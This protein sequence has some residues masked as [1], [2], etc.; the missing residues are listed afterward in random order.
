MSATLPDIQSRSLFIGMMNTLESLSD[1]D[2]GFSV[3]LDEAWSSVKR[4]VGTLGEDR[5]ATSF[6]ASF[7]AYL[8]RH[9]TAA[10]CDSLGLHPTSVI[11]RETQ[12]LA[13]IDDVLAGKGLSRLMQ[14]ERTPSRTEPR[15]SNFVLWTTPASKRLYDAQVRLKMDGRRMRLETEKKTPGWTQALAE[16]FAAIDAWQVSDEPTELDYFHQRCI[17]M[18]SLLGIIPPG[19]DRDRALAELVRLLSGEGMQRFPRIEWIAHVRLLIRRFMT[20]PDREWVFKAL[21]R[22]GDPVMAAYAQV[23][24]IVGQRQ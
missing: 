10:R 11:P 24:A 21:T 7:R 3:S 13:E 23:E 5:L 16:H 1:D 18:F 8:V 6:L 2:V 15:A 14:A 19:H 4:L 17:M 12:V 20:G 9:V 22:S